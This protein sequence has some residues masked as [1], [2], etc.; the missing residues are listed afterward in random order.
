MSFFP[1]N[2][3]LFSEFFCFSPRRASATRKRESVESFSIFCFSEQQRGRNGES[4]PQVINKKDGKKNSL[5]TEPKEKGRKESSLFLLK[6][7]MLTAELEAAAVIPACLGKCV[8]CG[9]DDFEG[10]GAREEEE[11]QEE[12]DEEWK[13]NENDGG[14]KGKEATKKGD[15]SSS[16]SFGPRTMILCTCCLGANRKPG[17]RKREDEGKRQENIFSVPTAAGSSFDSPDENTFLIYFSFLSL[18][19][20]PLSLF[21]DSGT[22]V[23][24]L[25]EATGVT[26]DKEL[27]EGG[28]PWF[29]GANCS[30]ASREVVFFSRKNI[31]NRCRVARARAPFPFSTSTPSFF[32]SSCFL[33]NLFPTHP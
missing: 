26:V 28:A 18:S 20:L 14:A 13:E 5:S 11:Q 23:S 31:D 16:S 6:R 29:C 10:D 1:F 24:C 30:Q 3:F 19:L 17:S 27:V 25:E 7:K 21:Q 33:Q 9:E 2:L 22:H 32:S 4:L 12:K 15:G 8:H